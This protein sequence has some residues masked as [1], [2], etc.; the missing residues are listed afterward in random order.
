M[1]PPRLPITSTT[2]FTTHNNAFRVVH[3]AMKD[4]LLY[5]MGV[6]KTVME[7]GRGR[8]RELRG[9]E[10]RGASRPAR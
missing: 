5:R 9:L 6:A 7:E 1:A 10:R 4:G 3:D 8:A 2:V